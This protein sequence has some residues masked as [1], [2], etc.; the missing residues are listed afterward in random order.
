MLSFLS[1]Y[2]DKWAEITTLSTIFSE[3]YKLIRDSDS[4]IWTYT[5]QFPVKECRKTVLGVPLSKRPLGAGMGQPCICTPQCL[6][7]LS[8][9]CPW[10]PYYQNVPPTSLSEGWPTWL[11]FPD[12]PWGCH[13]LHNKIMWPRAWLGLVI[14]PRHKKHLV[15]GKV[16]I[17]AWGVSTAAHNSCW[18]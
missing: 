4:C 1:S 13:L 16:I 7:G 9:L 2:W 18:L 6:H 8:S 15:S 3:A 10:D 17:P 12:W 5:K 14:K 11:G